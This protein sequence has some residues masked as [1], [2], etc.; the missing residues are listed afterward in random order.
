ME[1][2]TL[3]REEFIQNNMGLVYSCAGRFRGRG[4]EYEDLVSAGSIGLVKAVDGFDA[5]RGVCFS[6]YAVP[7]ILGEMKKL[8]RDGGSVKVSRSLKELGIKVTA[9]REKMVKQTGEEPTLSQL[10]ARLGASPQQI[11]LAIRATQPALS[12]TPAGEEG[13]DK[14]LDIPVESHEEALAEHLS[15][16]RELAD[17][18]PQD[19]TLIFLRFY[20]GLTQ[21]RT[22]EILGTTQVQIS[23][24]ERRILQTL[25]AKLLEEG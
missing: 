15:L 18:P 1:G 16:H 5:G 12:L 23:R 25:R 4:M 20:K 19:R 2:T 13:G 11:A 22:A 14:E 21:S 6:T 7:V 10:S 24:R 3:T 8:F 9:L 17:L